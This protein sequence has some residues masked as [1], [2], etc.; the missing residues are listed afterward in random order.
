MEDAKRN[1]PVAKTDTDIVR[2]LRGDIFAANP[3][4]TGG[5]VPRYPLPEFDKKAIARLKRQHDMH[6]LMIQ[7]ERDCTKAVAEFRAYLEGNDGFLG[8]TV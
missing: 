2:D 7:E 1:V 6:V 3:S 8:R 4:G 5:A